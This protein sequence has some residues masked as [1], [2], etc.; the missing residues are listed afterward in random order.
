MVTA[1]GDDAE[2]TAALCEGCTAFI[3]KSINL[4]LLLSHLIHVG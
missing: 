3:P 1:L 4:D 2:V